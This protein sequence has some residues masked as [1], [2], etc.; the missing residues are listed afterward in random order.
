MLFVLEVF[1]FFGGVLLLLKRGGKIKRSYVFLSLFILWS[2]A[3]LYSPYWHAFGTFG[4]P[5]L[6][7]AAFLFLLFFGLCWAFVSSSSI[8]LPKI[9][10][11]PFPLVTLITSLYVIH[12]KQLNA[13][14]PWR[15]DED[16]HIVILLRLKEYLTF[17]WKHFD[18]YLFSNPLFWVFLIIVLIYGVLF[19]KKRST[20][21][22][23]TSIVVLISVSALLLFPDNTSA[24]QQDIFLLWDLMRYPF[25][26]KW[27]NFLFILPNFYDISLYRIVPFL[28]LI[29]I[30]TFLFYVFYH[31]F[32]SQVLAFLFAFGFSTVPLLLFYGNILYLEMPVIL[33]MFFCI[34]NIQTLII[35]EPIKLKKHYVW[36][37]LLI[38][39]FLKE[40]AAIFLLLV[41]LLRI[42]Y[43]LFAFQKIQRIRNV[44]L[45]EAKLSF[46][47][48]SPFVLYLFFRRIFLSEFGSFGFYLNNILSLDNY[49]EIAKSLVVQ[50]GIVPL[51]AL[52]GFFYLGRKGKVTVFAISLLFIGTLVYFLI[53]ISGGYVDDFGKSLLV[54]YSRW[55]LYFIPMI[56]FAAF[57][58][59]SHIIKK[60]IFY[61]AILLLILFL[62]NCVLFPFT[63]EGTRL[64]NWGSM[65][66]DTSE[67]SYPYDEATHYLSNKSISTILLVGQYSQY[68]G[69]RFY[70]EK[71]NFYPKII[72]YPFGAKRF[73]EKDERKK[74]DAFFDSIKQKKVENELL[75]TDT[76][77]YHSVNNID[78]NMNALY[79]GKFKIDKRVQNSQ[80]SIYIFRAL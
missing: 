72:E 38:V 60:S 13:D 77:L 30:A 56:F 73:D 22:L 4:F 34:W 66:L 48:L 53:Y 43:Q 75:T 68:L 63:R 78:L 20:L 27:M 67:Y 17:F 58:F 40:T 59:V 8:I 1:I 65:L 41:I 70:L 47:I 52:F 79:G 26:Q 37:V 11:Y 76:I 12:F 10:L 15:G 29:G 50:T 45:S 7:Y 6:K 24:G 54:G 14:I 5:N 35:E 39:S 57:V 21:I 42:L 44:F 16:F 23:I 31:R 74:L 28:S 18:T 61:T 64:P 32:Q 3:Y 25:L 33:L 36:Y 62:F 55:N 51:F 69:L 19:Y 46:L 80:N 2:F 9:K 71:Y 49:L